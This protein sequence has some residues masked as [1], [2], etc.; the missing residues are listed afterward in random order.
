MHAIFDRQLVK[1]Q[2]R[3]REKSRE[4]IEISATHKRNVN[5]FLES[6][7]DC[8]PSGFVQLKTER[9]SELTAHESFLNEQTV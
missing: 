4:I 5:W 8:L 2:T 3:Q 1:T 9:P 7:F 6:I